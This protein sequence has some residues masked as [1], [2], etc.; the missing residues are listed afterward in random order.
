MKKYLYLIFIS[1]IFVLGFSCSSEK[2]AD[3]E[4]HQLP[5]EGSRRVERTFIIPGSDFQIN[6]PLGM[7]NVSN[8][9]EDKASIMEKLPFAVNSSNCSMF[10]NETNKSA[11]ITSHSNM[12]ISERQQAILTNTPLQFKSESKLLNNNIPCFQ[13]VY[14]D[15]GNM[16]IIVLIPDNKTTI[17][18]IYLIP[19]EVYADYSPNIESS[20]G[21]IYNPG[22]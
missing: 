9:M 1:L 15:A 14:S 12:S 11:M 7:V 19:R 18:V 6:P 3:E 22:I 16:M 8:Q 4:S 13:Y 21:S 10:L 20:L 2:K 5:A 17:D